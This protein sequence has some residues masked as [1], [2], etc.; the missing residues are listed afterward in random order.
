MRNGRCVEKRVHCLPSTDAHN[1]IF[2]QDIQFGGV[3][4]CL[5][6]IGVSFTNLSTNRDGGGSSVQS[7]SRALYD[8]M[9]PCSSTLTIQSDSQRRYNT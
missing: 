6:Y 8:N 1:L 9:S 5:S 4:V 3:E 2:I 7:E